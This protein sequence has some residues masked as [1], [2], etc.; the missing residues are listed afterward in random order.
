[1]K[2]MLALAGLCLLV[3]VG[4]LLAANSRRL[5]EILFVCFIFSTGFID[6]YDINFV[7]RGWYPSPTRGLELSFVDLMGL[8][9]LFSSL[10]GLRRE[11]FRA[12]WPTSLGLM[13][14]Y[15]GYGCLTVIMFEPKL[16]GLMELFKLL[17]G[18]LAFLATA[19]YIRSERDVTV[20][21][22]ALG[23]V[24]AYEGCFA[25]M[26]RYFWGYMRVRGSFTHPSGLADYCCLTAPLL[27]SVTFSR[28]RAEM[29]IFCA[30]GWALACAGTILSITRMGI[31]AL[32]IASVG[33]LSTAFGT[34]FNPRTV[35]VILLCGLI[36]LGLFARG[37]DKMEARHAAMRAAEEAGDAS[38]GRKVYYLQAL[39]MAREY[40]LGAGLNNYAW[41]RCEMNGRPFLSTSE[42]G[43]VPRDGLAHSAFALT[44]GDL[45]WPGFLIFLGLW[46]RWLFMTGRYVFVRAPDLLYRSLSGSF[47]AIVASCLAALTEHNFRNQLFFII[48]N[49]VLGFAVA[50]RHTQVVNHKY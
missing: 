11:G 36:A 2:Y 29:Q 49:I 37:Y 44:L 8:M 23:T 12:Y 40:P 42:Q 30:L 39:E 9:L 10:A 18:L 19:Y 5:R 7:Y 21:I 22:L 35:G 6:R 50:V 13:L 33:V 31:V 48:F 26:Q 16:F 34:Q 32:M 41:R 20:F 24:I 45:G 4:T 14:T 27:L 1:M 38:A 47:F 25:I 3:P 46:A 17:R 15:M 28:V 43:D